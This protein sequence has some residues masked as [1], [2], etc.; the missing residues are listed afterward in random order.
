MLVS[1]QLEWSMLPR[2]PKLFAKVHSSHAD[3]GSSLEVWGNFPLIH[4]SECG[5]IS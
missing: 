5:P 1:L 4:G 3:D 2:K